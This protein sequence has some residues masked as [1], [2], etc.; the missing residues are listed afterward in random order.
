MKPNDLYT[1]VYTS[2]R[3]GK[4]KKQKKE[5]KTADTRVVRATVNVTRQATGPCL[6]QR[7][8]VETARY[9]SLPVNLIATF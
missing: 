8:K 3:K 4:N 9:L 1:A 7:N 2:K 6:R 5:G